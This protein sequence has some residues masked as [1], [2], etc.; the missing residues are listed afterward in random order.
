[1]EDK[2]LL[3]NMRILIYM[4]NTLSIKERSAPLYTMNLIAPLK[5]KFCEVRTILTS[6]TSN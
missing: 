2:I 5:K 4:V 1:M 6:H 3:I